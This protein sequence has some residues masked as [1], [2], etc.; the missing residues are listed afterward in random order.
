[1]SETPLEKSSAP[2]PWYKYMRARSAQ[3]EIEDADYLDS[4]ATKRD[5]ERILEA[6][7]KRMRRFLIGAGIA[8]VLVISGGLYGARFGF[9]KAKQ[10]LNEEVAVT[11]EA[12]ID[13]KIRAASGQLGG[14]L[15]ELN[16]HA[17]DLTGLADTL[18]IPNLQSDDRTPREEALTILF[19][20]ARTAE[21]IIDGDMTRQIES[22][23]GKTWDVFIKVTKNYR[24]PRFLVGAE[25]KLIV[26]SE[27][28]DAITHLGTSTYIIAGSTVQQIKQVGGHMQTED[29]RDLW[30]VHG[31]SSLDFYNLLHN[32]GLV[33][34]TTTTTLERGI[35]AAPTTNP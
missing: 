30:V 29:D 7:R 3:S 24:N 33:A 18:G 10:V 1:M 19:T 9:D 26:S 32:K 14:K 35:Q 8:T 6:S 16:R 17:E 22:E 2:T 12:K 20:R 25:I 5:V 23:D 34:S 4:P 28:I 21:L 13:P 15:D 11:F 31:M 27:E